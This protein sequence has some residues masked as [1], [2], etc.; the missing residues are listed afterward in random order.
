MYCAHSLI[1]IATCHGMSNLDFH[2]HLVPQLWQECLFL[3]LAL[4]MA[5]LLT[6]F[7]ISNNI[8]YGNFLAQSIGGCNN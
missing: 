3:I 5:I 6:G 8:L 1:N 2:P 7:S 4:N